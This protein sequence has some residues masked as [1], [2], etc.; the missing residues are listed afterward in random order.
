M[1]TLPPFM[2][3]LTAVAA[4]PTRVVLAV[5]EESAGQMTARS[6][7]AIAERLVTE[8]VVF[9]GGHAGFLGG[10]Y[11]QTGQPEAFAATLRDVLDAA[12]GCRG[13]TTAT[14]S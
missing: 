8:T 2:P 3:D 12:Q 4:A 6:T 5:G 14:R 9:P 1:V 11:G 10:E 7:E 13:A